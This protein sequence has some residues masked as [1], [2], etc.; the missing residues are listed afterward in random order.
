[1]KYGMTVNLA[2]LQFMLL[3]IL[4]LRTHKYLLASE[5]GNMLKEL[6]I[7]SEPLWGHNI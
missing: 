2:Q 4:K 1:M 3:A 7:C 6:M 5:V